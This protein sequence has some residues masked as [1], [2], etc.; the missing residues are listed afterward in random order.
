MQS[1]IALLLTGTIFFLFEPVS[2][3][4]EQDLLPAGK[5]RLEMIMASTTKVPFFGS[6]KSA[7]KSVSLVE[8]RPNGNELVQHHQVCD[9]RVLED[10]KFIK[11]I[12]PEKFIASLANHTYPVQIEKDSQGWRYRADLG[13]ERIGYRN[14]PTDDRLPNKIDDP[15]VF[16]WDNDGHP[17]A[18]LQISIPLLPSGELYIV[19]RGQSVLTGY[20]VEPGK[21]EGSIHVQSFAQKVL[22][23]RPTFLAQSP[24]IEPDP[25]G[26]RFRL[27]AVPADASCTSLRE[28]V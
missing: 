9:F 1:W 3:A 14:H 5:Y 16:D 15:A 13:V 21:V 12:F 25:T 7:S 19:Q 24:E 2:G 6:S 23:A 8:I 26:S 18:T 10:S 11:M 28:K 20:V 4:Q 27:T 22:G 17:G